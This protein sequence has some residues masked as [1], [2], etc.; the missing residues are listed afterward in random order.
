M[1]DVIPNAT[2]GGRALR[3][4]RA[5]LPALVVAVVVF[6]AAWWGWW[7]HPGGVVTP[8][9]AAA[10]GVVLVAL[11]LSAPRM[12]AAPLVAGAL[13]VAGAAAWHD[14]PLELIVGH[15]V[16]VTAAACACAVLL[17]WYARGSFRLT[18]V[19]EFCTLVAAAAV[20]GMLANIHTAPLHRI[21]VFAKNLGLAFQITDDVLDVTSDPETL[22]KDV[23][24][25]QQRLT[26]VKLAGVEGARKLS[27][28]LVETSLTAIER[29]GAAA[30]PLR[31]LAVM[32][33]DR[34]R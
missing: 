1:V 24:K 28:E 6:G 16:A 10:A 4:V 20:G 18:R 33:R 12:W 7:L 27:E 21:E 30:K 31:E 14:A 8:A 19:R 3:T 13:A 11:L 5:T 2:E 15:A 32:V 34:V 23:G 25:D 22:G 29:L 26:F 17:R 9:L